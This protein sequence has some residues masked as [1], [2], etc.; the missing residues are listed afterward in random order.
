MAFLQ[1]ATRAEDGGTIG[2]A[3][4]AT[5]GFAPSEW[6]II[7]LARKD[8]LSSLRPPSRWDRLKT[9][10]FGEGINPRLTDKR[11][12][13]LR[14]LSVDAWHRGYTVRPS[15][16]RAFLKAGFNEGQLETLLATISAQR[17][18]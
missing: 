18:K 2:A 1:L 3:K 7:R 4:A 10:I 13:S 11:M 8:G 15:S 14:H 9:R 12:E 5:S 17:R 6:Q 16:L